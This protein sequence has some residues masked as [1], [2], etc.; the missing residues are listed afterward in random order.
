[1]PKFQHLL[2]IGPGCQVGRFPR[3]M[4]SVMERTARGDF[5]APISGQASAHRTEARKRMESILVAIG[6][7]NRW[8]IVGENNYSRK[9]KFRRSPLTSIT[10]PS[11]SFFGPVIRAPFTFGVLS[12]GPT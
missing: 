9:M 2:H 4:R 3:L 7:G 12:P 5:E 6:R 10:S 11:L 8:S 1:M